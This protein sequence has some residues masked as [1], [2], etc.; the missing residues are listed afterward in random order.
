MVLLPLPAHW[1]ISNLDYL[2]VVLSLIQA[3]KPV[4]P[5]PE[6]PAQKTVPKTSAK[7]GGKKEKVSEA[8][9]EVLADPVAEKLRQQR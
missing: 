1:V 5:K 3:P 7:A 8:A 2:S 9:N 6:P 4:A